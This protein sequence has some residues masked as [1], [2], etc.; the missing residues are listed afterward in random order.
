MVASSSNL[1]RIRFHSFLPLSS[2]NNCF[3]RQT[4]V[5]GS[6]L[7]VQE[8]IHNEFVDRVMDMAKTARMG[9]PMAMETQVGP[10][11]TPPQYEKILSYIDVAKGEGAKLA[12][13]GGPARRPECGDASYHGGSRCLRSKV[14]YRDCV[15]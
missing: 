9:D 12:L 7:L 2:T 1:Y 3:E 14:T 4:C 13:G 5:A 15:C 10:V 6:R 11:T 8:S